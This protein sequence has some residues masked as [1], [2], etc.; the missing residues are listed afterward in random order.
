MLSAMAKAL[1]TGRRTKEHLQQAQKPTNL[2][3]PTRL[4]LQGTDKQNG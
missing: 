2:L 1:R 4:I 3:L